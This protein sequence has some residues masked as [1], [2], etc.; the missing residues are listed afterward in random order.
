[1]PPREPPPSE[2]LP[3]AALLER[4]RETVRSNLAQRRLSPGAPPTLDDHHAYVNFSFF[5]LGLESLPEELVDIIKD[6]AVRLAFDYNRLTGLS[7]LAP[8]MADFTRL[9]YLVLKGNRLEEIPPQ[10]FNL[11]KLSILDVSGNKIRKLPHDLHR[12]SR[13]QVL[14][15]KKNRVKEIPECILMMKQLQY[16]ALSGNPIEYPPPSEFKIMASTENEAPNEQNDR[17]KAELG[18]MKRF[19][20]RR[21]AG[22]RSAH[23]SNIRYVLSPSSSPE[24]FPLTTACLKQCFSH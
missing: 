11:P 24:Q 12:L 10:V 5:N 20:E 3:P 15:M 7:G 6:H 4:A 19:F 16:I 14:A 21:N 23:R 9:E 18:N 17:Y 2:P 22:L 8:R 13:L 1:M